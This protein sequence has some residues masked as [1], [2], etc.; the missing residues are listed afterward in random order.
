MPTQHHDPASLLHVCVQLV[1]G[2]RVLDVLVDLDGVLQQP[3]VVHPK[4]AAICERADLLLVGNPPW[5]A[6]AVQVVCDDV[7][8]LWQLQATDV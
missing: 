8:A 2:R 3:G 6:H 5:K 1:L 7:G 4:D